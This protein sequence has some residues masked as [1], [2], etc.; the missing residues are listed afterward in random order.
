MVVTWCLWN[1]MAIESAFI[2]IIYKICNPELLTK[3]TIDLL[4]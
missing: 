1:L 4:H 2:I 3:M